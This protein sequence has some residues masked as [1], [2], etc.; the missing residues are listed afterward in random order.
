M[1]GWSRLECVLE[2][3]VC[4][5]S[6]TIVVG[7][8]SKCGHDLKCDLKWVG[9]HAWLGQLAVSARLQDVIVAGLVQ[10]DSVTLRM[11]Q[12]Y[13]AAGASSGY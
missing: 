6:H 1:S 3:D 2:G 10:G 8:M 7:Q 9:K 4:G 5:D 13:F 11:M 12:C